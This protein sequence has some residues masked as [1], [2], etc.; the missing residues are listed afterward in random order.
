ME[1]PAIW[2]WM[3]RAYQVSATSNCA[4]RSVG[5]V[6]VKDGKE[7]LSGS[8]GVNRRF[9]S[10]LDASCPRCIAGGVVGLGYDFCICVHA[11][12]ETMTRGARDGIA[13]GGA[14][15]FVTLRPCLNCLTMMIS[16]G[17][18]RVFYAED[19][20]YAP[21]LEKVYQTVAEELVRFERV[22]IEQEVFSEA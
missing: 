7:L 8:N 4:R 15:A 11:E 2:Q 1:D 14:A 21:E 13:I 3:Q 9:R 6:L 20:S 16:A 10:C 17:I 22:P 5:A 12:Q 18:T 19:W